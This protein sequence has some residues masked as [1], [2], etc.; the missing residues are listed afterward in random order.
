[1]FKRTHWLAVLIMACVLLLGA[2]SWAVEVPALAGRVNDLAAGTVKEYRRLGDL[3]ES[4]AKERDG[5]T[6]EI[7]RL[8]SEFDDTKQNI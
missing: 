8:K 6:E 7:D 4:L 1:M 5:L 2:R 3:V